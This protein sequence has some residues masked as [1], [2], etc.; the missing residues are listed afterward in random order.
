MSSTKQF[1]KPQ[2]MAELMASVKSA[3]VSPKKGETL[4]G[5]ITKI[6][7]S[8]ILVDIG[9]KTE[10]VVMEKDKKILKSLLSSIKLG[11]SVTVGVLNPES[12]MGHP[13]VSLRRFNDD[14]V[15]KRLEIILK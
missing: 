7:S 12:D 1:K 3:F 5:K 2:T 14:K 10:A 13:V 9:A 11:D 6:T 4:V 8:E 15:W